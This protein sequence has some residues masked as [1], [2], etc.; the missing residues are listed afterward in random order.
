ML[1]FASNIRI[2]SEWEFVAELQIG[3][4]PR[5]GLFAY[6]REPRA[7]QAA[8]VVLSEEAYLRS[9]FY[10]VSTIGAS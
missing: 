3:S 7:I 5:L 8:S 9:A 4:T 2:P 1:R 10:A 6:K